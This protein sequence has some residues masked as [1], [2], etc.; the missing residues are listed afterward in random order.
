MGLIAFILDGICKHCSTQSTWVLVG[1]GL[2]SIL[3]VSVIINVLQ[4]LLFKN[5]H[6]PPVVFHWFPFIGSTI[7]YG[8]DPYKFFFDCRAKVCIVAAKFMCLANQI[9]FLAV[10]RYLHIHSTW[11]KDNGVSWYEGQ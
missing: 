10:W 8:I 6:E 7:S 1:I 2:L 4:Q 5:P 9:C 3:A 11:Q